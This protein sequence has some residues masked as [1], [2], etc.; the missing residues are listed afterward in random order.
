MSIEKYN[1]SRF[2]AVYDEKGNL[3]CVTVYKI[4]AREVVNRLL[5]NSNPICSKCQ[6]KH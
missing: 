3:V 1:D 6:I 4:G 5:H 2:W